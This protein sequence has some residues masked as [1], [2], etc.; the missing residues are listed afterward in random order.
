MAYKQINVT[1]EDKLSFLKIAFDL[2]KNE[3][4]TFH[5]LLTTYEKP[6]EQPAQPQQIHVEVEKPLQPNQHIIT[7]DET[8]LKYLEVNNG[9]LAKYDLTDINRLANKALQ[10]WL[11]QLK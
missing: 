3:K 8:T 5:E 2:S 4:D 7:L 1:P 10:V 9:L 11:A 6:K